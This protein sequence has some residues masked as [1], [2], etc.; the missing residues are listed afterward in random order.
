MAARGSLVGVIRT[1]LG[2]SDSAMGLIMGAWPLVYIAFAM[3]N[4]IIFLLALGW[5]A[6]DAREGPSHS[7]LPP[8]L[9]IEGHN[10][11]VGITEKF[12]PVGHQFSPLLQKITAPVSSLYR[13]GNLV[14]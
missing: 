14:R 9:K 7:R 8:G 4:H 10:L 13:A 1:D 3:S 11:V 6:L 2:L 5:L 12:L